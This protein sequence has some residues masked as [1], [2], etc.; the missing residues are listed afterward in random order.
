MKTK[1]FKYSGH[2]NSYTELNEVYFWTITINK[3]QHLLKPAANKINIIKSLQWLVQSELVKIYGFVIMP[4][5]IHL[6]WEQL[7]MNGKEFPKNSF[8]KFTAKTFVNNMKVTN[9]P[10]LK[11]YAVTAVDREYNIWLRDPLAI[12]IINKEM[13]SQKLDYMHLNPM[14][15]HWLLCN[16]P[17]DYRFSSARFYEQNLDEFGLLTHFGEVF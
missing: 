15:P 10:A 16:N 8:E 2:R 4:N 6:M 7:K 5:H 11:N 14:Q 3:W 9:D 12:R 17:A 13:A 1:D